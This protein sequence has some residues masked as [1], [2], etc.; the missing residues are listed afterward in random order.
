MWHSDFDAEGLIS[1]YHKPV[2]LLHIFFFSCPQRPKNLGWIRPLN[3]SHA[4]VVQTGNWSLKRRIFGKCRQP[5]RHTATSWFPPSVVGA[6]S[7][8]CSKV[9]TAVCAAN[10]RWKKNRQKRPYSDATSILF[11]IRLKAAICCPVVVLPCIPGLVA[12][13]WCW[14]SLFHNS[15][16]I[17]NVAVD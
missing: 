2:K 8:R 1:N 6:R 9:R 14:I 16:W 15:S 17:H 7:Q 12:A 11:S 13:V 3:G 5:S 10:G 4:S